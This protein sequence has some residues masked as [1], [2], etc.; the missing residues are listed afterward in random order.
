MALHPRRQVELRIAVARGG[1]DVVD[2]VLE[3][4]REH[5]LGALGGGA[6]EGGGAEDDPRAL[7]AGAAER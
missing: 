6:E 5:A 2:A 3:Q 4:G 1:V 7:M